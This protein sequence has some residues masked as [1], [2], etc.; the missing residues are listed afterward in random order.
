MI[1]YALRCDRGHEFEEWFSSSAAFDR[2]AAAGAVACPVC[3]STVVEKAPMA[4]SV[5]SS[6]SA[7]AGC[8]AASGD[9]PPCSGCHCFPE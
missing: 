3:G 9:A 2:E 4:P 5:G 8:P 7:P 1:V 6:K